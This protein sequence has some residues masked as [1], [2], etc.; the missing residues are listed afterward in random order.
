MRMNRLSARRRRSDDEGGAV[1]IMV[2]VLALVLITISAMAVDLGHAFVEKNAIQ[3][4]ADFAALAGSAGDD[5]PMVAAGS[6]CNYGKAARASDQAIIDTAAYLSE[7]PGGTDINPV[8]LVDCDLSDGEAGYGMFKTGSCVGGTCLVANQNQLTVVSQPRTVDFG[9]AAVMGPDFQSVDV[10][11]KATVEIKSPLLRTLPLYAHEGC[12]YGPQT[13]SQTTNGQSS[14][15]VNLAI[16]DDDN[17]HVSMDPAV[18]LAIVPASTTTPPTVQAG[19]STTTVTITGS[20]LDLVTRV[21]FFQSGDS[22]PAQVEMGK[23]P[24]DPTGFTATATSLTFTIPTTVTNVEDVWFIRLRGINGNGAGASQ[25]WTPVTYPGN[26]NRETN[27]AARPFTVGSATMSCDAGSS[28]GNFG[29]LDLFNESPDADNGQD[30]NIAYNIAYGLQ[31]GLAPYPSAKWTPPDY[32]CVDGQDGVAKTWETGEDNEGTNCVGTQTGLPSNPAEQ[33][34]VTGVGTADEAVLKDPEADEL[35]QFDYPSGT[36]HVTNARTGETISDDWLTCY[37][38][39]D[40]TTVGAVSSEGYSGP[41]VIDQSIYES[42]RF[43]NVPVLGSQPDE[44]SSDNFQIIGFRPGFITDQPLTA[45]R[46]SGAPTAGNGL[47]WSDNDDLM[48]V[49]IIFLNANA[50]PNPPLDAEGGYIPYTGS[51]AKVPLLVN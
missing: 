32:Q 31:Y 33:G 48:A 46:L 30:E 38:L 25:E 13:I 22:P 29:T 16:P 44:G 27:L 17:T 1:A 14:T 11:G 40:T 8:D 47:V 26:A 28:D 35:C 19:S 51:G 49:K 24:T 5:L 7:Q 43:V 23:Q 37:F 20:R 45:T 3:K 42:A 41:A 15:N 10:G 2:G 36:D 34:F 50:L 39:D 6:D 9:L 12:D 4:R 21:G 18:P